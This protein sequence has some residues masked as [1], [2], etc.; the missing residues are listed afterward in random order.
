MLHIAICDDEKT[1]VNHLKELLSQYM[2]RQGRRSKLP[3]SMTGLI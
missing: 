1:F 3:F 2:L